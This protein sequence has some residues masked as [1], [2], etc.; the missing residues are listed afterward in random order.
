MASG[1]D[2]HVELSWQANPASNVDAYR[3]YRSL[4]GG[5]SY[6]FYRSFNANRT[7]FLDFTR[8][9]GNNL[10]LGYRISAV[11]NTGQESPL[12]DPV[13][14]ATFDMT[15]DELMDMVQAYTFRYFWD[16]AH[17]VSGL[18]R[19]RNTSD[20]TVTMGGTGFG[21]MAILVGIE[22]GFITYQQ[23]L[24]RIL[25][26]VLFLENADRFHGAYPHWMNGSTGDVIPF[27]PQ[28]NG[29]DIVET[30][31]LFEGLL[32]AREYFTSD[33]VLE[34]ILRDKITQLWE[35][36]EWDWYRKLNQPVMYWHWSPNFGYAI[37][38]QLRGWNET[39]IVYLLAAASPTHGVPGS[40]YQTGW[41][42]DNY[43]N[44][45]NYYGFNL[46][47]G[48]FL[49]GPLFFTHYSF[50]GFDPRYV[51]DQYTNY[52]LQNRNQTLI[53][54]AYC[55]SN[56]GGYT[57][58]GDNCWG[59]TA[60]DN[61]FGYLAHEP[62][63]DRDNGTI[64]PTAALS[65][66]PYTPVE[67]IAALKHFYRSHGQRLWGDMGFRDA[68][69]ETEDWYASSYL[70]IDQGPIITMI[71]NHRSRL[72]WNTFMS[73][74]EIHNALAAKGFEPDSTVNRVPVIEE[75]LPW[76]CVVGPNPVWNEANI[77]L[78]FHQAATVNIQ[79]FNAE[80]KQVAVITQQQ[81]FAPGQHTLQWK[82]GHLPSGTYYLRIQSDAFV[83]T[84]PIQVHQR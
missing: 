22:R 12:S 5:Q 18:I 20:E 41:L 36:V 82:V 54:R 63:A 29:G 19:E 10:S 74:T 66:M 76:V 23:G 42:N 25:T 24:D 78:D 52:F 9:W 31:F 16:F 4:D 14:T 73:N 30:A 53:N 68:F 13:L 48:R 45:F 27:S 65:S 64:A 17:P 55:I 79:L 72:L 67:S 15:D 84:L 83:Q 3:L 28:D 59:L 81:H 71:E 44:G 69:N 8:A 26:M 57:G 1:Y 37:N 32:T 38:F 49:G 75:S 21:I 60:S 33:D 2:S 77:Q 40:L 50:I 7:S 62:K 47:V 34:N 39:M 80:A 11:S 43:A 61:P 56:P 70:A 51:K 46:P 6:S 58:Y 35:T